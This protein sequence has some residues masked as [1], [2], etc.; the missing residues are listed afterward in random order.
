MGIVASIHSLETGLPVTVFSVNG[1]VCYLSDNASKFVFDSGNGTTTTYHLNNCSPLSTLEAMACLSGAV[2]R[3]GKRLSKPQR[4]L[5]Q[6]NEFV[7]IED[8][9]ANLS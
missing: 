2:D 9:Q 5:V 7:Q 8:G 1:Y 6:V 4:P 3:S